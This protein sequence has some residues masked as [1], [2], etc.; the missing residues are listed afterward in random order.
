MEKEDR[1]RL[2]VGMRIKH[3]QPIEGVDTGIIF[4]KSG[5]EI[6]IVCEHEKHGR[7]D[8]EIYDTEVVEILE[9]GLRPPL[10]PHRFNRMVALAQPETVERICAR[11]IAE[12][13]LRWMRER[14]EA[15]QT[16][17]GKWKLVA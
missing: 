12:R 4:A 17:D 8:M 15:I 5:S 10:S 14:G 13:E 7:F 9:E 16:E 1:R 6:S 11:N 2:A 3:N